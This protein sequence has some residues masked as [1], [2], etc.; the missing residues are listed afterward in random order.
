MRHHLRAI[1]IVAVAALFGVAGFGVY[2]A[3]VGSI[4]Q[5][6]GVSSR[7]RQHLPQLEPD[8]VRGAGIHRRHQI[9]AARSRYRL[10]RRFGG[11]ALDHVQSQ[12]RPQYR[13]HQRPAPRHRRVLGSLVQS[14]TF[15]EWTYTCSGTTTTVL[16]DR[17][18]SGTGM[19]LSNLTL[20]AGASNHLRFSISLPGPSTT[21]EGKVSGVTY[22]F[23]AS[24]RAATEQVAH[25][26]I[27][28]GIRPP[29]R[30][31]LRVVRT[32][33]ASSPPSSA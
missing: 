9:P 18:I 28:S 12:Q 1:G 13:R 7:H 32:G 17:A 3:Y 24:Q 4:S 23:N 5:S 14:G 15:Y 19:T 20:T 11:D 26:R 30:C 33:V 16:A 2:G 6:Q 22:T 25:S 31:S 27:G 29:G 21:V 10:G 8:P